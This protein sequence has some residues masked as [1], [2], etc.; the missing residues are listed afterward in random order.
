MAT[1]DLDILRDLRLSVKPDGTLD[2]SDSNTPAP[3]GSKVSKIIRLST[4]I[5]VGLSATG[6]VTAPR[7]LSVS[8]TEIASSTP[9]PVPAAPPVVAPAPVPAAPAPQATM[10]KIM[11][12]YYT[13]WDSTVDITSI[14]LDFNVI[15]LFNAQ[16]NGP[17]MPDGTKNNT[18]D[19]SFVMDV[20]WNNAMT[21]A[22]IQQVRARGQKVILSVGGAGA[23]YL[24]DTRTKSTNFVN[25]FKA[26]CATLGGV[27]GIDYN[28][29]EAG[30]GI[31]IAEMIWISQQL[32]ATYGPDFMITSP[33]A[34]TN[35]GGAP[36]NSISM[37]S[38]VDINFIGALKAVGLLT[39][40]GPQYYDW[41]FY[42]LPGSVKG[43]NDQWVGRLGAEYVCVGLSANY[44]NG[45]TLAECVR[46]WTAIKAA[47]PNIRGVFCWTAQSNMNNANAWGSAMK[48]QLGG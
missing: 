37:G 17:V 6:V 9:G 46:E 29:Y 47:Y 1:K 32:R 7:T 28:N 5:R 21:P 42:K 38:P 39:Y 45:L 48:A 10:A 3:A 31:N 8:F 30:V 26:I 23:G 44:P 15:Y 13:V 40:V 2:V 27:D 41:D 19:G 20:S 24:F 4:K 34:A 22:K 16:P 33:P 25:S 36:V 35:T 11:G 18:G 43:V 12:C 14:P